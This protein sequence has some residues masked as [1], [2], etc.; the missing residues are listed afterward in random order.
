MLAFFLQGLFLGFPAAA[1]PGPLQAFFLSQTMRIGWRRTLPSVLAPLISDGPII[2]IVL[3]LLTQL[4]DWLIPLLRIA[5]GLFILY[6]AV[7]AFFSLRQRET[8][9]SHPGGSSQKTLFK[10]T[11]TNLL[12]PNPY[13]FW[14]FVAGPILLTAWRQSAAHGASFMIGFYGTLVGGFVLFI[15]L[16]A[17]AGHFAPRLIRFFSSL[18]VLALFF[19]GLYQLWTGITNL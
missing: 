2:L 4:P 19:F 9:N 8:G 5:G 18:A 15:F 7:N 1:T 16:F 14:S 17:S 11:L 6:L 12:N 3:F 10:A 13:I